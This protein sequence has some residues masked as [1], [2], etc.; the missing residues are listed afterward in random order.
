MSKR[1]PKNDRREVVALQ[2]AAQT[3][4]EVVA[5]VM[6]DKLALFLGEGERQPDLRQL[7]Q[8]IARCAE[9]RFERLEKAK[10]ALLLAGTALDAPR[11]RRD[12]TYGRLRAMLRR[13]RDFARGVQRWGGGGWT[14]MFLV[15]SLPMGPLALSRYARQVAGELRQL[16]EVP[17]PRFGGVTFDPLMLASEL[18]K[19]A[20]E[21]GE[22]L[23]E[24][25]EGEQRV[26]M[27]RGVKE[28]AKS[29]FEADCAIGLRLLSALGTYAGK[30]Q[31]A[32]LVRRHRARSR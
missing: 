32:N 17:L 18:E 31:I 3:F 12:E 24:I 11:R 14:P 27:A 9:W 15:P 26:P 10:S 20:T 30:P 1:R 8:L 6:E 16:S 23:E 5:P 28:T 2:I 29:R 19:T 7:A 21:L 13:L 22:V 25:A 4:L